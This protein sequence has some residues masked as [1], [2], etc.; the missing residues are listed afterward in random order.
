MANSAYLL[1][2]RTTNR[3][4]SRLY[5]D[6]N[7]NGDLT[8]DPVYLPAR[9]ASSNELAFTNVMVCGKVSKTRIPQLFDLYMMGKNSF[10]VKFRSYFSGRL[11]VEGQSY[12]VALL[13]FP[14]FWEISPQW[15]IRPWEDRLLP[16][17]I[18]PSFSQPEQLFIGGHAF[19]VKRVE[20]ANPYS[21]R[22]ELTDLNMKTVPV[23]LTGK[24][25][26]Q[27]RLH[28]SGVMPLTA[29]LF[30][31]SSQTSLPRGYYSVDFTW[32]K[33]GKT[34]A[35][36]NREYPFMISPNK[37]NFFEEGGPLT[38]GVVVKDRGTAYSLSYTLTGANGRHYSLPNLNRSHSP[39]VRIL[40]NGKE[41]EKG[42]FAYG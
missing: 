27:A 37:T 41:I 10:R 36:I 40:N 1:E 25:L 9:S 20:S 16:F 14:E 2:Y 7:G 5:I 4:A 39:E 34:E 19:R 35:F 33:H 12:Q 30:G 3:L 29:I 23:V 26:Y 13:Y 15:M 17:G 8:D 42:M 11:D 24:Y 38:N 32:L 21:C 6:L 18:E 22:I 31:S 28:S